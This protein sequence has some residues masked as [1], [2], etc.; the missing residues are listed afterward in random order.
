MHTRSTKWDHR[1]LDLAKHVA[2][3]SKD[4]STK[5]GAILVDDQNI[6]VGMGYNGFA[7]G[8]FDSAARYNDRTEKYAYIVHAEVNAILAA[9]HRA[10]GA[11]LYVWP[12]FGVPNVCQDCAKFAIQAGVYEIVGGVPEEDNSRWAES[13]ARARQMLVEAGVHFRAI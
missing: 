12:S 7:R 3:W 9:G 10:R 4:P 5:V 2:A 13:L 8:V 11:S 6:V 1:L